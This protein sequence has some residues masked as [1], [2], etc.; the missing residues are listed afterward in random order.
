MR[1]RTF[2]CAALVLASCVVDTDEPI[3]DVVESAILPASPPSAVPVPADY[4]GDGLTDFA[5]KGANGIWY[6]DMA[7]CNG[8]RCLGPDGFGGR[9]DFAYAGYGDASA[10][11]V[12]AD[13]GRS[14]G[15][16]DTEH[17][18]DLAVKDASGMWAIDYADNGFGTWDVIRYGYGDAD[19]RPAPAD[20]DNDGRADLAVRR[21]NGDWY[22]DLAADG[23]N[24]WNAWALARPTISSASAVPVPGDYDGDGC[25]DLAVKDPS[26]L[27]GAVG[28]WYIDYARVSGGVCGLAGFTGWD[29]APG[30]Y[31]NASAVPVPADYD[32]DG[33]TDIAIKDG[34]GTWYIAHASCGFGWSAVYSGFGGSWTTAIPGHFD[35]NRP[36]TDKRLDLA[37]ED[38][39][40]YWSMKLVANG[41]SGWSTIPGTTTTALYNPGRMIVNTNQP[42]VEWT[43]VYLPIDAAPSVP[44]ATPLA[45]ERT[46]QAPLVNGH[47]QLRIGVRYT[48]AVRLNPGA[49]HHVASV[50]VNPDLHV[51]ATLKVPNQT[52]TTYQWITSAATRA[53]VVTCTQPGSFPLGFMLRDGGTGNW[54]NP[55]YGIRVACSAEKTGLYGTVT[56]RTRDAYNRYVAGSAIAG[57]TVQVTGLFNATTTTAADGSWS[58]PTLTGGPYKVTITAPSRTQTIAVN[59]NVPA[60]SGTKVDAALETAFTNLGPGLVYRQ[61]LDY[62]RGRSLL[63]VV[64]ATTT[65]TS[66]KLAL[67]DLANGG[68]SSKTL[69]S[70]AQTYNIPV[71]MNGGFFGAPQQACDPDPVQPGWANAVGY[72]YGARPPSTTGGYVTSLVLA[73]TGSFPMLAIKGSSTNQ[74]ISIVASTEANFK[75]S[76]STQWTQTSSGPIYDAAPPKNQSDVSYAVQMVPEIVRAGTVVAPPDMVWARTTVGKDTTTGTRFW[77]VI[78]D[79]EGVNGGHGADFVQLGEFYKYVLG[80]SQAM[81]LDGGLSTEL[82]LRTNTN[83]WRNVN[84]LTGED[85]S[86]DPD[87][88]VEGEIPETGL[89]AGGVDTG[90]G[91]VFNYVT[92]GW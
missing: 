83:T 90:T 82:V 72:F 50:E 1:I 13:Y 42:Y 31:G 59:V 48:I 66:I 19:A 49:V 51:P 89:G 15:T 10:I 37:I 33:R 65:Q 32:G 92:A 74:Q 68:P 76:G 27:N 79:G 78:A 53:F 5:L 73:C 22:I 35:P 62:S 64:E 4:D 25:A 91:S 20:F 85:S 26:T 17:K 58:L 3:T 6:I 81:A 2:A 43:R 57:A 47:Y 41:F 63:H 61:Y 55:D 18:A 9:W 88:S 87:P 38:T 69:V 30:G 52:G 11:P 40:G 60:G 14:D 12:P 21:S 7:A 56:A 46:P 16:V 75:A 39:S 29:I 80:A 44:R 45:N 54:I 23:F 36:A 70:N 84:M 86:W 71:T 28:Y 34:S 67:S 24:G 8:G 77:L